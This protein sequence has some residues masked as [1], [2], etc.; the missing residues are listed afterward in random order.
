MPRRV[1]P[2]AATWT[3]E[4]GHSLCLTTGGSLRRPARCVCGPGPVADGWFAGPAVPPPAAGL[5]ASPGVT[6]EYSVFDGHNDLAWELRARV[7]Y[8]LDALDLSVDHSRPARGSGCGPDL[9]DLAQWPGAGLHTDLPRLQAGGVAAQ[10]WSV[11]VST[12]LPAGAAVTATLEQ[13]DVVRRMVDRFPAELALATSADDV[14][15]ARDQG[16]IA[17]LIGMEGGH[18]IDCSLGAL[19]MMYA[20]GARYLTL[21]HVTNVPWADS[22][23][24]EPRVGGLSPFGHEVVRELNRLG[25]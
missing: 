24:D 16:R 6:T 14:E 7:R 20:L 18:S 2:A 25:M 5:V 23:T 1:H 13:I 11:W 8:D 17:S 21:T 9:A 22:A 3:S 15:Q 12:N 10:Y 19:R 4:S